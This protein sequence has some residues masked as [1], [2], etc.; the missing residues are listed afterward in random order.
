MEKKPEARRAAVLAVRDD[1]AR[2][3]AIV[4]Q[5]GDLVKAVGQQ[6]LKAAVK[7]APALEKAL[8]K[9]KLIE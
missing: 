3:V 8:K 1:R 6:L 2:I 9:A 7:D 5:D 4:T